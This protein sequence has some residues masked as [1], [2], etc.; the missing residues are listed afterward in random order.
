MDIITVKMLCELLLLED[1]CVVFVLYCVCSIEQSE[2]RCCD[3]QLF[4]MNAIIILL[5]LLLPTI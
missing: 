4:W 3:F 5:I 2:L 1:F